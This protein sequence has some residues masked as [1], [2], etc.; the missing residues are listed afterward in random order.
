MGGHKSGRTL[1]WALE[2]GEIVNNFE[3]NLK[4]SLLFD[5]L[6][7]KCRELTVYLVKYNNAAKYY[8]KYTMGRI[9]HAIQCDSAR[10]KN[11]FRQKNSGG[12]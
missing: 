8:F 1:V 9:Y 3:E 6:S 5:D 4:S 11:I 2:S 10:L 7:W 12:L